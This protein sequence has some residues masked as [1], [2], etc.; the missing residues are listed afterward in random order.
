MSPILAAQQSL[1]SHASKLLL[2]DQVRSDPERRKDIVRVAYEQLVGFGITRIVAIAF[3]VLAFLWPQITLTA[4][5]PL[6]C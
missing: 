6:G 4:L 5:V 1:S 3:G 2:D